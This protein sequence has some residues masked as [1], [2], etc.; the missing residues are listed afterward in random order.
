MRASARLAS[1]LICILV[2]SCILAGC[3][4]TES[5]A[6]IVPGSIVTVD[7]AALPTVVGWSVTTAPSAVASPTPRPGPTATPVPTLTATPTRTP[8]PVPTE[9]PTAAATA[10]PLDL[11]LG[12]RLDANAHLSD[13]LARPAGDGPAFVVSTLGRTVYAL[14]ADGRLQWR[15]R[16]PGAVYALA[17]LDAGRVAAAGDEGVT[18][19][20][21]QGRTAWRSN[22]GSRVTA[23]SPDGEGGLLAGG[24]DERLTSLASD[25]TL[26]W[27]A[28][29]GGP[30][31]AITWLAGPELAVAA[32]ADGGLWAFHRDGSEAWHNLGDSPLTGLQA[33]GGSELL[34]GRQDGT[35][36]LRDEYGNPAPKF[37]R[38]PWGDGSPVWYV[39][40]VQPAGADLPAAA[41]QDELVVGTGG[42]HAELLLLTFLGEPLWRVPLPSAANAVTVTDWDGPVVLVG[43]ANG[44]VRAYDGQGRLRGAVQAGLPV[45]RLVAAGERVLA[46][47]DVAAWEIVPR[48]GPTGEAWLKTPAL[49]PLDAARR[50][51]PDASPA[52]TEPEAV[53]VFLGDVVPGRSMEAQLARFGPA[54][55]WQGLAPLLRE[56]DL[57]LANLECVLSTQGRPMAKQYVIRAH[58]AWGQTLVEAGIDVVTLANN[59]ALDYGPEALDETLSTLQRLGIPT[60]GA[61]LS[62]EEAR[63]P[64]LFTLNGIRVAV[65]GYAAARWDGSAD[66]PATDRIAWAE[67]ERVQADIRAVRDQV[68]VVVVLLHAGTEYARTPSA[69]QVA[70]AR[71]AIDAGA[72]L[73]VGHHPH[74]TQTVERYGR[75]LIVYSLGDALFDI[76]RQAAMQGDLLRVHV[77]RAGLSQAELWPFWIE[78]EIRPRLLAAPDDA[79][80]PRFSIVYPGR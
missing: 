74:V 27:Q 43:L 72:D 7:A 23:L 63:R 65:L 60:V 29:V 50:L 66:V 37:S 26:A 6:P 52:G 11:S 24:W 33:V 1:R 56:A 49:A 80:R 2:T 76:P 31:I 35:L 4:Q 79:G 59:H 64:A 40:D 9:V 34:A 3:G 57:A 71:A 70:V 38:A 21:A 68:D 62:A 75:G 48:P 42:E 69:D 16:L 46:M 61:G 41:A 22:P 44:E 30:V 58:P 18:M 78:G 17:A 14:R 12:W 67:P 5:P 15:A 20:D 77:T 10:L 55:P 45:S 13:A 54:Y 25:G 47:A 53:L 73:V 39:A 36:E 51:P 32:T 19:L 28:G 8:S